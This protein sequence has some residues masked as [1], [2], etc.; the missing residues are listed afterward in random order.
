[1]NNK[2]AQAIVEYIEARLREYMQHGDSI[3][4][5]RELREDRK[6]KQAALHA[7]FD[8]LPRGD[9]T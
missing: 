7:V 6:Q 8:E 2:Q 1:M 5:L 3:G 9:E 4:D